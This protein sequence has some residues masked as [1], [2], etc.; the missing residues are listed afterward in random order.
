MSQVVIK[1]SK[2]DLKKLIGQINPQK[3]FLVRGKKSFNETGGEAFISD[4]LENRQYTPFYDF[5]T[6]PT[7]EDVKKGLKLFRKDNYDLIIAIGGGS[8]LDTA[9]LIS[10]FSHSEG[11]IAEIISGKQEKPKNKTPLL[12]IPTTAGTGSEA[13]HFAV[14]YIN[15]KKHSVADNLI[16]PDYV[17][18]NPEFTYSAGSYLTACTG[19]DA[20]CQSVE[21]VWNVNANDE[22]LGYALKAIEIIWNNLKKAVQNDQKAKDVMMEAAFLAGKAINITKTTAP[23]ALSY[24]FTSRYGIPH[25]HAVALSLPYFFKYNYGVSEKD[26]TDPKGA[27]AVKKRIDKIL[28][29]TNLDINNIENDLKAFFKSLGL[30]TDLKKLIGNID[31]NL[32]INNVN[33]ERLK[34]NPRLVTGE[35]IKLFLEN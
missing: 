6:N 31:N 28:E 19:A 7:L 13:T 18:L 32:I 29:I 20:F 25:G 16:L 30:E 14:L 15:K 8:V 35:T 10:F 5:E 27:E 33:T 4:L 9:K 12:A 26:C 21:S 11:D 2:D 1:K 24:I 34:N 23:H 17:F 22:S 3:V